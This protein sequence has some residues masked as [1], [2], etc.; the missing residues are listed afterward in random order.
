MAR[1]ARV[2]G[3]R[4]PPQGV[5]DR[6]VPGY[7]T[8]APVRCQG[9]SVDANSCWMLHGH[10]DAEEGTSRRPRDSLSI[11]LDETE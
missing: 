5:Q 8:P 2:Y 6:T 4:R 3:R 10:A 9:S 11:G 7:I 1:A